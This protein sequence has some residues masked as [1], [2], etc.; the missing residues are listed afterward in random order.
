[1]TREKLKEESL[2]VIKLR[3]FPGEDTRKPN[4]KAVESALSSVVMVS[5]IR[6]E[7]SRA[8]S[9][10]LGAPIRPTSTG[11]LPGHAF[12]INP[13]CKDSYDAQKGSVYVAIDDNTAISRRKGGRTWTGLPKIGGTQYIKA[14][15]E[16]IVKFVEAADDDVL[17]KIS[18]L[19]DE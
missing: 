3:T 2:R 12:K 18:T 19:V 11:Y 4:V 9:A 1:M 6:K 16:E 14:T 5:G 8:F 15:E 13:E 10:V 7:L 17:M